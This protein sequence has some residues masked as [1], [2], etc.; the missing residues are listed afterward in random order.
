MWEIAEY[1]IDRVIAEETDWAC[2]EA[3]HIVLPRRVRVTVATAPSAAQWILREARILE[4]LHHL[5]VPRVYD[6]G[7]VPDNLPW[8]AIE[9][10]TGTTIGSSLA[11][12]KLAA[13]LRDVGG[14]LAHAHG[15]GVVH[16]DVSLDSILTTADE[17]AVRLVD[18]QRA[19]SGTQADPAD[20]IYALGLAAYA[21][22]PAKPPR[23]LAS[24]I[25]DM[26][27]DVSSRP[28]AAMVADHAARI[29]DEPDDEVEE[30]ALLI[31]LSRDAGLS[32]S[33]EI[34]G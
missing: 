29:V 25:A 13:L 3:T 27:A 18:W 14:I 6:C 24:L 34:P 1:A 17:P 5:G 26:L 28:T 4:S 9:L 33:W 23:R 11:A 15:R 20:D 30:V 22:M 2:F 19:R 10:V 32:G 7:F 8:V 31:D 12:G 21:V 16:G